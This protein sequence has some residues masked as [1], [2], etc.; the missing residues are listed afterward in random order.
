MNWSALAAVALAMLFTDM[1]LSNRLLD[2]TPSRGGPFGLALAAVALL[3]VLR[4]IGGL[5]AR[6]RKRWCREPES[7]MT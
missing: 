5:V 7:G 4:E 6:R 2:T 3:L 1:D